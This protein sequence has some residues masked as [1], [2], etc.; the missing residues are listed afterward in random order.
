M[1]NK[2]LN[3]KVGENLHRLGTVVFDR[4]EDEETTRTV[5]IPIGREA[6]VRTFSNKYNPSD[7]RHGM[8]NYYWSEHDQYIRKVSIYQH[9]GDEY[10]TD[11]MVVDH[12]EFIDLFGC[13]P[14]EVIGHS[15]NKLDEPMEMNY[16]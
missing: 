15:L 14:T 13:T 9:K 1:N 16:E 12:D 10:L 11:I 7:R 2:R 4:D 3:I 5:A 6:V 8:T